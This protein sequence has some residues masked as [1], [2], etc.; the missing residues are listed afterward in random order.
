MNRTRSSS[1]TFDD[2][3]IRRSAASPE[4]AA[5]ARGDHDVDV[6][7]VAVAGRPLREAR[8]ALDPL[9]HARAHDHPAAPTPGLDQA[10]RAERGQGATERVAGDPEPGAELALGREA[11]PRQEPAGEDV[12]LD[13]PKHLD[14]RQVLAVDVP[15]GPL[16]A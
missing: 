13:P 16:S 4:V 8:R 3:T 7:H 2:A 12:G 6:D 5:R 9:R 14:R 1:N 15:S 11:A 10:L